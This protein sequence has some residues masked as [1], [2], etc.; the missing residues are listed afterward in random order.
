MIPKK[1]KFW[2]K[3]LLF[4]GIFMSP[5]IPLQYSYKIHYSN[6][7]LHS[8]NFCPILAWKD[9]FEAL[10][11]KLFGPKISKASGQKKKNSVHL[12]A[13]P[14]GWIISKRVPSD[15]FLQKTKKVRKIVRI[16]MM[17]SKNGTFLFWPL[18]VPKSDFF[19]KNFLK[20]FKYP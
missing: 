10:G 11:Q 18:K 5:K 1:V 16:Q 13:K 14:L 20:N 19:S 7:L 15:F 6:F 9:S 4:W 12:N 8:V 17:F 3:N 2:V